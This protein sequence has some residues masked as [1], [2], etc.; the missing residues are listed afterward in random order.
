MFENVFK[1]VP[2]KSI[3]TLTGHFS[4]M[5]IAGWTEVIWN[6][7]LAAWQQCPAQKLVNGKKNKKNVSFKKFPTCMLPNKQKFANKTQNT[8]FKSNHA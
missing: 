7:I 1:N 5:G 4:Q 2:L 6:K 3:P 8:S